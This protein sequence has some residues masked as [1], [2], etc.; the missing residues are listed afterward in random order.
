MKAMVYAFI[1]IGVI[2]VGANLILAELGD[3]A[4]DA[5]ATSSVRLD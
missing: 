3:S 2:A 4:A 5:N 1:A